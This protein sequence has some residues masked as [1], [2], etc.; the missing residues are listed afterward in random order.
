MVDSTIRD[1]DDVETTLTS[2]DDQSLYTQW[3]VQA[4]RELA[5]L[6]KAMTG[7]RDEL[8]NKKTETNEPEVQQEIRERIRNLERDFSDIKIE[9][10]ARL[11]AL[12]SNREALRSQMNRIRE[13]FR[14]LLHADTTLAECIR[15]LFHEQE[16]TIAS[17]PTVIGM[18]M[19]TLVLALT[20]GGVCQLHHHHPKNA[21]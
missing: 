12:S 6:E 8:V 20:G 11:E 15:T 3:V 5:G 14:R 21:V 9:R 10:D 13:N 2:N 18:E 17:I 7:M 16:I 1:A 19:S 4:R